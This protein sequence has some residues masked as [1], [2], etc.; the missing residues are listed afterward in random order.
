MNPL[1]SLLAAM[2]MLASFLIHAQS[3]AVRWAVSA[4][5][6]GTTA[7][8]VGCGTCASDQRAMAVDAAGNVFVT[9][10]ATTATAS[11]RLIKMAR[12]RILAA[13]MGRAFGWQAWPPITV[14]A[15]L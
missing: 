2:L 4:Y 1:R 11:D 7:A 3:P 15:G 13:G 8:T 5:G 6:P 10:F 9:G 14:G 12:R